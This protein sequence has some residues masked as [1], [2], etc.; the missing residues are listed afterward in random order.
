MV[1][2]ASVVSLAPSP[3]SAYPYADVTLEVHGF[4]GGV[5]MGQWGALGYAVQGDSYTQILDHY[6]G[7]LSS[8]QTTSIGIPPG[9][10]DSVPVYV[11]L[12]QNANGSPPNQDV[13]VT[14]KSAFTAAGVSVPAGGGARFAPATG[15]TW[16]VYTST[17]GC[18]GN[19]N[20]TNMPL[21]SLRAFSSSTRSSRARSDRLAGRRYSNEAMP[22]SLVWVAL[23]RT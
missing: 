20:W 16:D 18:G 3:A 19:G 22:A 5:G 13:I 7:T 4:G 21:T 8:G 9:W 23:L 2:A 10:S 14:S 12:T 11:A 1:A 6:Y 17:G 15:N